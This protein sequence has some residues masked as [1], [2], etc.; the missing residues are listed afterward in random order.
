MCDFR[1]PEL[2]EIQN[3]GS[4]KPDVV[5]ELGTP[6]SPEQLSSES[7][8]E[9][10][11]AVLSFSEVGRFTISCG[12]HIL[13]QPLISRSAATWRL[14]LL[15][16]V[17][18]V[19]LEQ[20]GFF[21]LHAGS[22][23]I[24]QTAAAFLGEKGQGKSTL[25]AALA[26][27]G[28]PLLSDDVVALDWGESSSPSPSPSHFGTPSVLRGFA[29]IKLTAE[30]LT[31]V[32]GGNVENWSRV[33]PEIAPINKHSFVAPLASR[34]L[35]LHNLFVLTSYDSTSASDTKE[36]YKIRALSPQEALSHLI[37]HTFGARFGEM[38]LDG[39][40]RKS[41][42]LSCSRVVNTCRVW[43]LQRRRDL[44]LLPS[45]VNAIVETVSHSAP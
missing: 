5:I 6:L 45:I 18:A 15:G 1:L 35:P 4:T 3:L 20:R 38:Y 10:D 8:F 14:P 37:P 25:N 13:V 9:S 29:Q 23:A 33:A 21:V 34:A 39:E 40:R 7:A 41:H 42:F 30:A 28:Y 44:K 24:G 12:R 22:V 19:L 31:S 2:E 32:V 43:E 36:D 17:L 26:V 27:S 16:A 11:H